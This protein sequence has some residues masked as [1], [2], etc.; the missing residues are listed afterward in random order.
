MSQIT[1]HKIIVFTGGIASGKSTVKRCLTT[2]LDNLRV[3]YR[4]VS[5]I[6]DLYIPFAIEKGLIEKKVTYTRADT[7]ALM[8]VLYREYGKVLGS[9]LLKDFLQT[10][11]LKPIYLIDSK[12][13][14]EGIQ[15]VQR[16]FKNVL[17]VGT[18]ADTS[19]RVARYVRRQRAFDL[20][21]GVQSPAIAM[22]VREENM[23]AVGEAIALSDVLIENHEVT[24]HV[25]EVAL[26]RALADRSFI[27]GKKTQKYIGFPQRGALGATKEPTLQRVD[28]PTLL[29]VVLAKQG[30][31]NI[32][33]VQ[34]GNRY[35][36]SFFT[37]REV[38]HCY[39]IKLLDV[40]K[41]PLHIVCN[42]FLTAHER[43]ML[44]NST[45][46]TQILAQVQR[47]SKEKQMMVE[48]SILACGFASVE[49]FLRYA[50]TAEVLRVFANFVVVTPFSYPADERKIKKEFASIPVCAEHTV[51]S[52][53]EAEVI[54]L[55][56]QESTFYK[57]WAG[58]Q[59]SVFIDDVFYR[60]RTYYALLV[61]SLL[62]GIPHF[63][64]KLITLCADRVSQSI[65]SDR[66]EVLQRGTL[67]PFENSIQTEKG[68]WEE[69]GGAFV[70]RDLQDYE[71]YLLALH[72]VQVQTKDIMPEWKALIANSM[73][74]ISG[75]VLPTDVI[76][77]LVELAVFHKAFA[78]EV[79]PVAVIDQRAKKIGYC[80]P[81]AK[82]LSVW[83]NQEE[84]RW[85]RQKF[86]D[87][88]VACLE[89]IDS[90]S[91]SAV[92]ESAVAFYK[93][94]QVDIDLAN[95]HMIQGG[96]STGVRECE[97]KYVLIGDAEEQKIRT[98]LQSLS[99]KPLEEQLETDFVPDTQDF[100][101]R[102][103]NLLLRFRH[104]ARAHTNDIL[105]TLKMG[106]TTKD[107]FKDAYE[108]QYY[109]SQRDE[110]I[111]NSINT[112][113]E[114][115]GCPPLPSEVH[116]LKN[117]ADIRA[118]VSAV[119]YPSLRALIQKKRE[120]YTQDGRVV[121][122]DTFPGNIGKYVE[123][124]TQTPQEL[125]DMVVALRLP[126]ERLVLEDYGEIIK[127]KKSGLSDAEQRT[128]LFH[129]L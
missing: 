125:E 45:Q 19:E 121:T 81:F 86:K 116:T 77:A 11:S 48:A 10:K 28:I 57:S 26:F 122:F 70:F 9:R 109:F 59:E 13:N 49:D 22:F 41:V 85:K 115:V 42:T 118:F 82:L 32:F 24:P 4:E 102:K 83:I 43:V 97:V 72:S 112:M 126:K 35:M 73:R 27:D 44:L 107:G 66:I 119:G 56:L 71:E 117:I 129:T 52:I 89:K 79:F 34:G 60:G 80:V 36:H 40:G 103:N 84:P 54:R 88:V 120:T 68:Y 2:L 37:K 128:A 90:V 46:R 3:P 91:E 123:I 114:K 16:D 92:F 53:E 30:G 108:L 21:D 87:A 69:G 76:A 63:K 93:H 8:E 20:V 65:F 18:Y 105:F 124:E 17:V 100:L 58:S 55:L 74:H 94:N 95:L 1:A 7:T 29:E 113:L 47:F 25:T 111:F 127:A 39:Q 96:Q 106:N 6:H 101:C 51:R 62:L 104:I 23:F 5:G 78:L 67:Y 33:V 98:L 110:S 14:P 15:E 12:R 38:A 64:W 99:F 75:G 61:I 50:S 31:K